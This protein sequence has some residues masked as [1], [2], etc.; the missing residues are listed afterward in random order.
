MGATEA[1]ALFEEQGNELDQ[2]HALVVM[3]EVSALDKKS[4]EAVDLANRALDLARALNDIQVEDRAIKVIDDIVGKPKQQE[5]VQQQQ[6][7][8]E[9][10]TF[11]SVAQAPVKSGMDPAYVKEIVSK[12]V[13]AS[14]ATDEEVHEDSPLMETGMD[15]LTS[16]AFRNGLNSQ[17]GMNLP[18]ALMF[19][20]PSQR[21]IVDHIIEI[22]RG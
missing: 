12:T 16:V 3:A 15:S 9:E 14:L 11:Q 4:D 21:A 8:I 10:Q 5:V 18:A 13:L 22:S 2:A 1:E 20:Y 6:F 17:L 7:F 19:D